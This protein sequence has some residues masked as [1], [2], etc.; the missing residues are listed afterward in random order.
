[1]C[2]SRKSYQDIENLEKR[3]VKTAKFKILIT[4]A[5]DIKDSW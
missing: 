2:W 5:Y 3:I 4:F 1:M